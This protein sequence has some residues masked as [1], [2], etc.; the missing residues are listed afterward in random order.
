MFVVNPGESHTGEA[1]AE[2]GYVYRTLYLQTE[3]L[4]RVLDDLGM[5]TRFPFLRGAIINDRSLALLLARFHKSLSSQASKLEQESFLLDA[6]AVLL[7]RYADASGVLVSVCA[8][9][10]GS[11]T[12]SPG[13]RW[14]GGVCE[15]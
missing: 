4:R 8:R 11:S 10:V 5:T 1:A 3:F 13:I 9:L 6:L 7:L 15:V 14:R 2:T 12:T